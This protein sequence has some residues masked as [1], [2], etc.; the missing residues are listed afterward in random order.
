MADPLRAE[1]ERGGA[2]A[3]PA[4]TPHPPRRRTRRPAERVARGALF[5]LCLVPLAA[6]AWAA[7]HGGLGANPIRELEDRTGVW[8]LRLLAAT[9]AITPLRQLPLPGAARIVR[10]RRM[11]G[12]FTFFYACVHLSMYVGVDMFF[13]VGDIVHD[14][15]KHR[16]ITLGMASFLML[17]PLA[18]T[19][20][21]GWIRRLGGRRWNRLHRL[22][23]VVAVG[24]TIHYLWAVKK[25]TFFPFLYLLLFAALL[26]W[27]VAAW[28][29]RGA[30]QRAKS[31]A[32]VKAAALALLAMTLASRP[33]HAQQHEDHEHGAL[34][35]SHPLIT[36]S[37]SPDTKL[38]LDV[39][40]RPLADSGITVTTGTAQLEAEYAFAPSFSIAVTVPY[41]WRTAPGVARQSGL[42]STEL[43]LKYAGFAL[44][45]W[46]LL[47]GGGLETGLPTGDDASGF[48]S[49]HIVDLEPFVDLALARG[50]T[51]LVG[52]AT[53]GWSTNLRPTDEAEHEWTANVSALYRVATHAEG[54]LELETRRALAG[55][56]RG[57]QMTYVAPGL[58]LVTASGEGPMIGLSLELPLT[59][60]REFDR[61]WLVSGMYHF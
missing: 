59:T 42:G 39:F 21:Q 28:A 45:E 10:Y 25:D 41:A 43:A 8:T 46:G 5:A 52:F 58:K 55:D 6:M 54:L 40:T 24:G 14:V 38:R 27:R 49:S 11:L 30:R 31:Y 13:D 4:R 44:H 9:L 23:Y 53:Y 61:Q 51:Q 26:G 29:V 16:Y 48:G 3:R 37:P 20:T 33:L 22:V 50:R 36:E 12:L 57:A 34:H 60:A 47:Y 56:E 18:V 17:I 15:V 35:F 2:A 7:L 19:S 1:P 32:A